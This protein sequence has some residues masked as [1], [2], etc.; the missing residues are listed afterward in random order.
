MTVREKLKIGMGTPLVIFLIFAV[1]SYMQA[2]WIGR[3]LRQIAEVEAPRSEAASRMEVDLTG[4]GFELLGYL[5]DH[6]AVRLDLIQSRK[7]DFRRHQDFYCLLAEGTEAKRSATMVDRDWAVFLKIVEE[8]V[9]LENYQAQRLA[10]LHE[11]LEEVDAI[12]NE[13]FEVCIK[14]GGQHAF[15]R[16][17][18]VTQMR[19]KV[20]DVEESLSCYLIDH[21]ELCE[22]KLY[23]SQEDFGRIV[24]FYKNLDS[25][26]RQAQVPEQL[27]NMYA[28]S[29]GLIKEIVAL[30]KKKRISLEHFV[31]I[32]KKLNSVL[33]SNIEKAHANFEDATH[34]SHRAVGISTIVTLVLVFIG[35]IVALICQAYI[36]LRVT[37]PIKELNDAAVKVSQGKYDT[38]IQIE[39]DDELGQLADSI[40]KITAGLKKSEMML[41]ALNE[42]VTRCEERQ[43][44]AQT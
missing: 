18:A 3:C 7:E 22:K 16:L 29:T 31:R 39:S 27:S 9:N 8:V 15:E 33:G 40:G 38:K 10:L 43:M 34:I 6:N 37:L 26:P 20:D 44:P 41:D 25:L 32:T 30:D 14:L 1:I 23:K 24:E 42:K 4:M 12:S 17:K 21:T 19:T 35:L 28:E 36:A 13:E 5:K 2:R 11:N